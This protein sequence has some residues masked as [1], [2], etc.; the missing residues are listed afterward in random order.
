MKTLKVGSWFQK[1]DNN[2]QNAFKLMMGGQYNTTNDVRSFLT[3]AK[4]TFGRTD[5]VYKRN[6]Q[7]IVDGVEFYFS[8]DRKSFHKLGGE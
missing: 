4:K 7:V 2:Q 1:F 8:R 3:C 5:L 6:F